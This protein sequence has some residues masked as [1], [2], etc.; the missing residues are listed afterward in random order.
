MGGIVVKERVVVGDCLIN[1]LTESHIDNEY[2]LRQSSTRLL[3]AIRQSGLW[4]SQIIDQSKAD[5]LVKSLWIWQITRLLL[6]VATRAAT[7]LAITQCEIITLSY[8]AMSLLIY[9]FQ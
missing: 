4:N 2:Q 7:S 6:E 8:S 1:S 5:T 9:L 3:T